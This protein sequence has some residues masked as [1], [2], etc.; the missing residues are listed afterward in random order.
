[1][2]AIVLVPKFHVA[3]DVESTSCAYI[4]TQDCVII[5]RL[6][7]AQVDCNSI[8]VACGATKWQLCGHG[9]ECIAHKLHIL[10]RSTSVKECDSS[11]Y[12]PKALAYALQNVF[13]CRIVLLVGTQI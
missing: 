2:I 9:I 13:D 10:Y 1:M 3:N 6:L 11:I 4:A 8:Y 7:Y 5:G 12:S